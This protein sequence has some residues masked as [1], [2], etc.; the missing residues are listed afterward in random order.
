M[1]GSTTRKLEVASENEVEKMILTTVQK[2]AGKSSGCKNPQEKPWKYLRNF[3]K[4]K[5][6]QEITLSGKIRRKRK[7]ENF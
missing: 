3:L 5:N 7:T 1:Q 4:Q 2:S 6:P